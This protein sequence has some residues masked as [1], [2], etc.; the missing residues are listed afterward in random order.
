MFKK[1]FCIVFVLVAVASTH[2]W[3]TH[4]VCLNCGEV[5][6]GALV[7]CDKCGFEPM[8]MLESEPNFISVFILFSD[9]HMSKKTL[10]N[11]GAV[12]K[13]L[14]PVFP[15]FGVR[16][17]ALLHYVAQTYPNA[18]IINAS[19]F[20]LPPS[21][22]ER[23]VTGVESLGLPVFEIEPGFNSRNTRK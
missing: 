14:K 7:P 21:L 2:A 11:F 5:H 17:W 6:F 12:V 19:K 22:Q 18:G 1:V 10:E 15:D 13:K 20:K 23:I 16:F 9:H 8:K 4:V 3:A